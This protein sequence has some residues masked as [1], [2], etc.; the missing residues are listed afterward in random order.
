MDIDKN[1]HELEEFIR[2][3][4]E[5]NFSH[6]VKNVSIVRSP[7]IS[8]LIEILGND[9]RHH[10]DIPSLKKHVRDILDLLAIAD[11]GITVTAF[12][13]E[14]PSILQ[15]LNALKIKAPISSEVLSEIFLERGYSVANNKWVS[16]RLDN[17]RKQGLVIRRP[18]QRY[19]LT[20]SGLMRLGSRRSAQSTDVRRALE[21]ARWRD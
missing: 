16:S 1:R 21:M 17:F 2:L 11:A 3:S 9:L 7:A 4:I 10:S 8:V 14:T 20:F 19:V 18:D 5:Q 13:E 6:H 12:D 15:L